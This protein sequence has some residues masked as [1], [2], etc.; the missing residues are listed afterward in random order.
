MPRATIDYLNAR[1]A[2]K[3]ASGGANQS[4]AVKYAPVNE[5]ELEEQTEL[6]VDSAWSDYRI[7]SEAMWQSIFARFGLEQGYDTGETF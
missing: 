3:P 2:L 7:Q 1:R 5:L 6:Q 4:R